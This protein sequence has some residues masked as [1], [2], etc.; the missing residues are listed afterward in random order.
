MS[1]WYPDAKA[2]EEDNLGGKMEA[3]YDTAAGKWVFPGDVSAREFD[4]T[5]GGASINDMV[6]ALFRAARV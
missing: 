4:I 3:Y 6:C 2:V 5:I 1:W